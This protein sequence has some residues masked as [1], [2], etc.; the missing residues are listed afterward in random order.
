MNFTSL[1]FTPLSALP[2]LID[3]IYQVF[4]RLDAQNVN[5]IKMREYFP[6]WQRARKLNPK[7]PQK[8]VKYLIRGN[9]ENRD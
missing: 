4:L 6:V 8:Y 7:N 3:A 9:G 5:S 1:A 2:K